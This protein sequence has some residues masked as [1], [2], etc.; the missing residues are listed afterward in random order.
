MGP[1][2]AVFL[3]FGLL[4]SCGCLGV[5]SL[6]ASTNETN[7]TSQ[8][9]PATP[10]SLQTMDHRPN[11]TE[12]EPARSPNT[13]RLRS[14][15]LRKQEPARPLVG[16][17]T[18]PELLKL[19]FLNPSARQESKVPQKAEQRVPVAAESV[20]VRCGEREVSVEVKK[21][22]LGNGQLIRAGDLT[23]GCCA[24]VDT[25]DHVLSFQALL[26]GC[27]STLKMTEGSLVYS[28]SLIY[29]PTPIGDTF[30]LKTSPAEVEVVCHYRR[31]QYVS[32]GAMRPA[33]TQFASD[34]LAEQRLHFS[35]RLMTEDWQSQRPSSVFFLSDVM[36]ME[37][38]VLQGHHVPLRVFVDS[39]VAT[40]GPDPF[41]KP[42][43]PF[44]SNHGCLTDAKLTGAKSY[45]MQ[46]SR[47]DKLHFLL[48]AFR[49]QRDHS[50]SIYITCRLK[51]MTVSVPV[52]LQHKA[53]SFLTEANR[54]VASGGDNKVCGCCESSCGQERPRRALV[55]D[56]GLPPELQWEAEVAL[57]P[58]LEEEE[59][60]EVSELPPERLLLLHTQEVT[61]AA[62]SQS[63]ALLC[64]LGAVLSVVLIS[65]M[66]AIT[67]TNLCK[68][69]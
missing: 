63:I 5:A 41:S 6:S 51:A 15:Q 21:N 8:I 54:W 31:R 65:F 3:G 42:S 48:K 43:Y 7:S 20:A 13:Y 14:Y 28:F 69:H 49:F 22:F 38:G 4:F 40:L 44:I 56:A 11:R 60:T 29:S 58:V 67:V 46:R 1:G 37:A 45:F 68:L 36:H 62:S 17:E 30:I 18:A 57:G 24:G 64:G 16:K 10:R 27:G 55:A 61:P 52:D 25:D 19:P 9:P 23:L 53:C 34:V 35:L 39:C 26:T 66:A 12:S 33:W 50:C 59:P 32:S 47:E 2:E